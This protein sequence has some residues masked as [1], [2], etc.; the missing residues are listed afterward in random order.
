MRDRSLLLS[1][2]HTSVFTQFSLK[3]TFL[4]T[5]KIIS[6]ELQNISGNTVIKKS[7]VIFINITINIT[8]LLLLL[9]LLIIIIIIIIAI[10][11]WRP[12]LHSHQSDAPQYIKT[13]DSTGLN[14]QVIQRDGFMKNTRQRY[15]KCC[16]EPRGPQPGN[17]TSPCRIS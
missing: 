3:C 13:L 15:S 10:A 5:I 11:T 9:W 7:V 6:C 8:L 16:P 14:Y 1:G 12:R 2:C 17:K 4:F